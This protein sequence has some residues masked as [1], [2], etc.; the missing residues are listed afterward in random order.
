MYSLNTLVDRVTALLFQGALLEN[1]PVA[2]TFGWV[3]PE[4]GCSQLMGVASET[5][6]WLAKNDEAGHHL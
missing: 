6:V 1:R 5:W 2:G 4:S 3:S